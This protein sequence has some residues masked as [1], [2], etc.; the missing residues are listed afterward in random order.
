MGDRSSPS[1]PSRCQKVSPLRSRYFSLAGSDAKDLELAEKILPFF[2]PLTSQTR[3]RLAVTR[4]DAAADQRRTERSAGTPGTGRSPRL[5]DRRRSIPKEGGHHSGQ[6]PCGRQFASL[7]VTLC[8]LP[9]TRQAGF[10]RLS[11]PGP[12][13]RLAKPQLSGFV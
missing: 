1:S 5:I 2:V 11:S 7:D 9:R 8:V 4:H 12:G 13:T 10:L 6:L 3:A